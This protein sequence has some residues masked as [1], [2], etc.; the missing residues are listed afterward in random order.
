MRVMKKPKNEKKKKRKKLAG[1][2]LRSY[3][4]STMNNTNKPAREKTSSQEDCDGNFRRRSFLKRSGAASLA[5][6]I[7]LNSLKVEVS[8]SVSGEDD[9]PFGDGA[10]TVFGA[11]LGDPT[12]SAPFGY[13][14]RLFKGPNGIGKP[15]IKIRD[16]DAQG[17]PISPKKLRLRF[18]VP[19]PVSGKKIIKIKVWFRKINEG[20]HNP[21]EPDKEIEI[22]PPVYPESY[23][24]NMDLQYDIPADAVSVHFQLIYEGSSLG[25]DPFPPSTAPGVELSKMHKDNS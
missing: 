17:N 13:D 10:T 16:K 25:T 6:V 18:A 2:Q 7:A 14:P 22:D 19:R 3:S 20:F 21:P 12:S 9:D 1:S 11:V 5:A 8:A 4:G 24:E 15:S 23:T